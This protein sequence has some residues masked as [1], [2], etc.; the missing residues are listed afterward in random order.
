MRTTELGNSRRRLRTSAWKK[1]ARA[2]FWTEHA[3]AVRLA[4]I[5]GAIVIAVTVVTAALVR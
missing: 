3:E 2:K 1:R 5:G 4:L